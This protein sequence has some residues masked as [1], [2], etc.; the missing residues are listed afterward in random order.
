MEVNAGAVRGRGRPRGSDRES[1]LGGSSGESETEGGSGEE[2]G[3]VGRRWEKKG[4][5]DGPSRGAA[6]T[7]SD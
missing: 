3:G 2:R 5:P 6:K 1:S 7:G 4:G